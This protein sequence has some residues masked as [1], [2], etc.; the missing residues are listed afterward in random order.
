MCC[1]YNAFARKK[2]A[3]PLDNSYDNH[4][5]NSYDS[6][7]S[8]DEFIHQPTVIIAELRLPSLYIPTSSANIANAANTTAKVNKPQGLLGMLPSPQIMQ[9]MGTF[10]PRAFTLMNNPNKLDESMVPKD[11]SIRHVFEEET[12]TSSSTRK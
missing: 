11:S 8:Y 9:A 12:T 4:Q 6:H 5:Y 2:K 7:D 10:L 1:S 3:V